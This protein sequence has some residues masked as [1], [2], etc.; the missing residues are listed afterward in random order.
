M[1]RA[2][3]ADIRP[4]CEEKCYRKYYEELPDFRKRKADA[5]QSVQGK[6]QS[7]GVW[8]LLEKI[9]AEEGLPES[10]AYNLSHSGDYVM[11]AVELD[12]KKEQVGCDLE[13][14]GR[15]RLDLAERF[16]CR[17]EYEAVL[18]RET[19]EERRDC[20]FRY[21]VLKE[22]FIKATGRGMALPLNSFSIRLGEPPVLIRQPEEYPCRYYYREFSVRDIPYKMAVCSTDGEIDSE[23]HM[24]LRLL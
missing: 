8:S 12:G 19:E 5:L 18:M 21:W 15:L 7:V 14:I 2:W 23:I 24:G 11:C 1:V 17:E 13:R 3:I 4:L 20:F 9:R 16:F 6:A 22:S 10:S